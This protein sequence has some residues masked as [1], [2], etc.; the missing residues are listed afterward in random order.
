MISTYHLFEQSQSHASRAYDIGKDAA[1]LGY[2]VSKDTGSHI[3]RH[4]SKYGWG[5]VGAGATIGAQKGLAALKKALKKT[6]PESE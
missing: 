2:D 6:T 4:K 3:Y 5:S 1:S